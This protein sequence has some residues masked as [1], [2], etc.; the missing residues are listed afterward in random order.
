M[1]NM[2][3]RLFGFVNALV[4]ASCLLGLVGCGQATA[5]APEYPHARLQGAVA[6]AGKPVPKGSLDFM[7]L[8]SGRGNATKAEIVDGRF[9]ADKVPLGKVLVTIHAMQETGKMVQSP[10]SSTPQPERIDLIPAKYRSGITIQV[11]GDNASQD[12]KL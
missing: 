4:V 11:T 10:S 6:V 9:T 2:Q 3:P 1:W 12:F 8:E 7:P 5:P